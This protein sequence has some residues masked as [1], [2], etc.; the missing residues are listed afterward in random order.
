MTDAR[1]EPP[2]GLRERDGWH[3]VRTPV[4]EPHL[5]RWH[6][7]ERADV[8]PLWT[9]THHVYSGTP[10]YVVREW[11]W[12]YLAPVATPDTVRA[13]VEA[14]DGLLEDTQ[15]ATHHCGD[16]DCPVDAARA[17]LARA[18]AEGL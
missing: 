8:E 10:R 11:G 1:C 7:A 18:K 6:A 5:A 13:L 14:L 4:G 9:S 2:E 3:W 15:H 16:P 12:R 17:A